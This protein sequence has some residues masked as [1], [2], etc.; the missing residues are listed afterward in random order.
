LKLDFRLPPRVFDFPVNSPLSTREVSRATPKLRADLRVRPVEDACGRGAIVEDPALNRHFRASWD[1]YRV[2]S[3]LDGRSTLDQVVVRLARDTRERPHSI[4]SVQLAIARFHAAELLDAATDSP[5]PRRTASPRSTSLLSFRIPLTTSVEVFRRCEQGL[6]W[7]FTLP[8][9]LLWCAAAVAAAFTLAADPDRLTRQWSHGLLSDNWWGLA[10]LWLVLKVMHEAG[11]AAAAMRCGARPAEAGLAVVYFLPMAYVDV[12]SAWNLPRRFDRIRV[13]LGGMAVETLIAF[14]LVVAWG[15]QRSPIAADW[16]FRAAMLAGVNTLLFNLNPLARLDGYHA[17]SDGW[18]QPNL[19]ERARIAAGRQA[20]EFLFG[21]RKDGLHAGESAWI[22]L[23]GLA[24]FAWSLGMATT[25]LLAITVWWRGWGLLLA[26]AAVAIAF[27]PGLLR[28][29]A[30]LVAESRDRPWAAVRAAVLML[31]AIGFLSALASVVPTPWTTRAPCAVV[32]RDEAVLRAPV[33]AF[34]EEV[35]VRA[36]DIVE[37]GRLL[38]RLRNDE[39]VARVR[40]LEARLGELTSLSD[41]HLERQDTAAHQIIADQLRSARV[42]LDERRAEQTALEV[43]APFAGRVVSATLE[44]RIGA[45]LESGAELLILGDGDRLELV[46]YVA[47]E[48]LADPRDVAANRTEWTFRLRS[49]CHG[50]TV[51]E[52]VLPRSRATLDHPALGTPLG[53]PLA[54][55]IGPGPREGS[56][57]ML[58]E[59]RIRVVCSLSPEVSRRLSPGETGI[60]SLASSGEALGPALWRAA[61]SGFMR[62]IENLAGDRFR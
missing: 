34:V 42:E 56:E 15:F 50:A 18:N 17:L 38:V 30:R 46:A 5:A 13:A 49:G 6:G 14:M 21:P 25:A 24:S 44:N 35:F 2:L 27:A 47:E 40:E 33:D 16:L 10:L 54:V 28:T 59:P 36:G 29:A 9:L 31:T 53:G 3:L 7:L 41:Q 39:L 22:A 57:P 8:G 12:S 58:P 20:I 32:I 62:G 19:G 43:R 51:P 60:V 45:W 11:H 37:P 61:R 26:G 1:D 4:D 52:R 48:D 55:D 23:F